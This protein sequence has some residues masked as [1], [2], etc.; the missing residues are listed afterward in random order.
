MKEEM[1]AH[2]SPL[3]PQ[4]LA[5]FITQ[6]QRNRCTL[7][8]RPQNTTNFMAKSRTEK[9]HV[10]LRRADLHTTTQIDHSGLPTQKRVCLALRTTSLYSYL[11][12]HRPD[13]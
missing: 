1:I 3:S 10:Q 5:G 6:H 7:T 13:H 8:I 11:V 12:G 9:N 2:S 4:K